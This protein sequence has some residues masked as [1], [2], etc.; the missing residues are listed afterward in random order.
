MIPV[1]EAL[2]IIADNLAPLG[3]EEVALERALNR[4]LS[5]D[6]RADHD[7]PPFDTSAMDGYAVGSASALRGLRVRPGNVAAGDA[8]PPPILP[9]EAVRVMTG[10]PLPPDT[11]LIVPV[12]DSVV[13]GE[14]VRFL[15]ALPDGANRRRAGEIYRKDELL[16]PSS[17]HLTPEAVVLCAAAGID[18]VAVYRRPRCLVVATGAELVAA[19]TTPAATQIRNS[20]GPALR[21]AFARRRI[22]A[23]ELEAV[24]DDLTVLEQMFS[25]SSGSVDLLVTTGGV[26]AG[27]FD[28]TPEAASRAGFEILFHR[29]AVKPGKPIAFGKRDRTFWFG[30]PGNPVSALTTFE[31]FVAAAL[32][33]FEGKPAGP[34]TV[35]AVLTQGVSEKGG[36]T[37]FLDAHVAIERGQLVIEPLEGRGSHD[38]M[39]QA[40]RNALLM[41]PPEGGIFKTGDVV[42][43][44]LLPNALA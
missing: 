27:D 18:P 22:A 6:V 15:R 33:R 14:T 29:V 36:R 37:A 7:F 44:V 39:C 23:E 41:I 24:E 28:L 12:E 21:A 40:R 8:V 20:N 31:I 25:E 32:N 43:A 26:S 38:V 10:G 5:T 35:E 13:E 4:T 11:A 30:L 3:V 19:R 34:A 17:S 2:A 9:H 42:S 1:S 16:L